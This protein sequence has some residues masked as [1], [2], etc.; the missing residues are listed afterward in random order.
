M[1]KFVLY[2]ILLL[3]SLQ[4]FSQ[5]QTMTERE[6]QN[7]FSSAQNYK[8]KISGDISDYLLLKGTLTFFKLWPI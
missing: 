5:C 1:K 4:T 2:I 8:A 7:Y 6:F 3:V